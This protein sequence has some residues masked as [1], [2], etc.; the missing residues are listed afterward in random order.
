[1]NKYM[2]LI[3][4]SII[5]AIGNFSSKVMQF[6]MVPIYSYT[7]ST[8]EFGKVDVLTTIVSLL[9]PLVCL[10][11]Y[12]AVFRFTM[13]KEENKKKVF[14]TSFLF[15]LF[16]FLILFALTVVFSEFVHS[17]HK[18]IWLL[19][20]MLV[21]SVFYSFISNFARASQLV[22]SY[23]V[24]GVISTF[25]LIISNILF[26]V[27]F[28]F[29]IYGYI[30]SII[31]SY[32]IPT[33]FLF[34][35][36][37]F[38][39]MFS[40]KEFDKSK[41]RELLI[42]S[43]PLIP[44]YISWWLNSSSDRLFI[45]TLCGASFNGLY[46][47][48]NK[49]PNVITTITS[50]FF[51]SWQI[52]VVEEYDNKNSKIF[53]SEVFSTF[54]SFM[55]LLSIVI[56]L[57]TKPLFGLFIE[58]S[59]FS[60]WKLV[61]FLL[62]AVIY[63]NCSSFLGTMYTASK[64]TVAILITTVYGAII[65]IIASFIL[66]KLIGVTGAAVANAISFSIVSFLRFREMYLLEKISISIKK[67]VLLH[68]SFLLITLFMFFIKDMFLFYFLSCCIIFLQIFIDNSLKKIGNSL[69]SS[70]KKVSIKRK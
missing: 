20:L 10:D 11:I 15:M 44:N 41:L 51:Q 14:N 53:I 30:F 69:V 37:N 60:A 28:N 57:L 31:I 38:R 32:I 17:N 3:N 35:R 9:A 33:G 70:I 48:A 46:A 40:F 19:F 55:F 29:H 68:C 4:N 1:M 26:L 24:S 36:I 18:Y 66:I 23:A 21:S 43:I 2:K 25:T 67:L 22:K 13:G 5:F 42:F 59:Y 64:K 12:D 27:V 39:K 58:K 49:I 34:F 6:V 65:N 7:L 8:S 61:P 45:L 50:V 63:S 47:M 52:S 62:I 54:C 56:L 16:T